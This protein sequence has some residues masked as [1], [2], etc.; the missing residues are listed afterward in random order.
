MLEAIRRNARSMFVYFVF[1]V[2]I[3]VFILSFGPQAGQGGGCGGAVSTAARVG[4]REISENSWRYGIL[5]MGGGSAQG[6]RAR[7]A[8]R[9][10]RVLD[11]LI[12]REILAQTAE[13]MGF[14]ISDDEVREKVVTGEIYILGE[15]LD[16]QQLYF[17]KGEGDSAPR[18]VARALDQFAKNLG[19]GSVERFVEEEKRELLAQK[20]RDLVT[21]AVRVSPEEVQHRYTLDASKVEIEYVPFQTASYRAALEPTPAEVDAHLAAHEADLKAAYE[22]DADRWK[23]REPEVRVRHL[24]VKSEKPAEP[25]PAASAPDA[26]AGAA[27]PKAPAKPDPARAKAD[28]ALAKI[29]AGQDFAAVAKTVNPDLR[30]GGDLGWRPLRA[31]RLGEDAANAVAK[32]E[33]GQTTEVIERPEGFHILQLLDKRE[34]DLAF[35]AVKRDLA[36]QALLDERAKAAAKA[37]ADKALAAAKAGTPLDKQFPAAAEGGEPPAA[38]GSK[39]R[40]QKGADINRVGGYIPGIG[41][42]KE[43]VTALFDTVAV[44]ELADQVYEVSG[45][46]FVVRLTKREEPDM[47]K[48]KTEKARIAAELA[49]DKAQ[50]S[51]ATYQAQRCNEARERGSIS[52]DPNLVTYGDVEGPAKPTY[53]PCQTLRQF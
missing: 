53:V 14:R 2:L 49:R 18:F 40:L 50:A 38:P 7:R 46:F 10:E 41:T 26:G 32:L 5:A 48:F 6:E 19:L 42:S 11:S 52:Y 43:L 27:P 33:K 22:K 4:G 23:G 29:K 45:D 12:V 35:D 51:L 28:A 20:V 34:G 1:G 47:E 13:D 24:F 16:G 9:R 37:D 3:I 36:E 15:K 8:Q 39:P 44:G 21:A 31:L 17:I 25:A 30:R